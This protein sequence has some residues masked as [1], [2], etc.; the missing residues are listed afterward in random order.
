M[1]VSRCTINKTLNL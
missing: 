1:D